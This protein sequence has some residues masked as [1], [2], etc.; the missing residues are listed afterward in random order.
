MNRRNIPALGMNDYGRE[1]LRAEGFVAVP[2]MHSLERDPLRRRP[3]YH[4]FFQVSFLRGPARLMHDFRETRVRGETL[5]F[6][7]PGQV[8][9]VQPGKGLEG[10]VISFTRD[11]FEARHDATPGLLMELPFYFAADAVP[12]LLIEGAGAAEIQRC[13]AD[14]QEE[15]DRARP[16]AGEI[17]RALLRI[18]L[19]K[20]SRLHREAHPTGAPARRAA[21]LVRSFKLEVEKHFLEWQALGPYARALGVSVN[22][23]NDIVREET[24]SAAGEHLRL[25]R[26]L[27]AKR[28]LLHSDLSIAEIGY[29]LGFRDPS[30]FGRFFRRYEGRPP[31]GFREEMRERYR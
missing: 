23:L 1:D 22:H 7:S 30:Y 5:F 16:G 31:A 4:D 3:H 11:F 8:H 2:F 9:T 24:G 12:W 14:I 26:L 20:A 19:V 10:V 21:A 15:F 17:L 29:R 18:L 28:L 6:L 13:C 25:R 27:D